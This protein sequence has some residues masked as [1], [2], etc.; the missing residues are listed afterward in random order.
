MGLNNLESSNFLIA[1]PARLESK[2]LPSKVL[3]N[4]EGK[5]MIERVI[6]NCLLAKLPKK[7]FLCTDNVEI[8]K[9]VENKDIKILFTKKNCSSGS[10]RISSVLPL[11]LIHI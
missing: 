9:C 10:E 7:V 2:R 11:S 1:I 8:A 6:D 3:A 4:I 5:S